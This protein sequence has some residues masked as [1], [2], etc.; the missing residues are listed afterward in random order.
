MQLEEVEDGDGETEA[1]EDGWE[2]FGHIKLDIKKSSS[3]GGSEVFEEFEEQEYIEVYVS[4]YDE[5]EDTDSE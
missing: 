2:I 4:S 1:D 3:E 5:E